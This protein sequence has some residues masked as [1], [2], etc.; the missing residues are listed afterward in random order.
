MNLTEYIRSKVR[1][2][3]SDS[4][5]EAL[6]VDR[7]LANEA[8]VDVASIDV[9]SRELLY[10]DS[11]MLI[12]TSANTTGG[13]SFSHGGFSQKESSETFHSTDKFVKIAMDIYKKYNDLKY[14]TD[15]DT[16]KWADNDY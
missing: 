6:L 14:A 2:S 12:S 11:L 7:D 3:I 10:A 4:N 8:L 13:A 5:I 15:E 1:V 9:K 16:L